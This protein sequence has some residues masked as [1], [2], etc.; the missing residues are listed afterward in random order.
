MKKWFLEGL[1]EV[2]KIFADQVTSALH[3]LSSGLAALLNL[4]MI[5]F[6]TYY[7]L[8]D[9]ERIKRSLRNF[10]PRRHVQTTV[11]LLDQID[12]VLGQYVRGQFLVSSFIAI[13]TSTGLALSDIRYA[14]LLGLMAGLFK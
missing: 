2:G 11:S 5:P 8:K 14:V 10:L 6:V 9:Y 4:L 7:V 12:D 13:L 1:P 3:G